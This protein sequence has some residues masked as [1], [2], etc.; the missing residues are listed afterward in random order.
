MWYFDLRLKETIIRTLRKKKGISN[1]IDEE[2]EI[3]ISIGV[4]KIK[5]QKW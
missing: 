4:I 2:L 3:G 1:I 5:G